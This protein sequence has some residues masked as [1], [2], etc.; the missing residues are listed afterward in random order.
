[1]HFHLQFIVW[2]RF[3]KVKQ[4]KNEKMQLTRIQHASSDWTIRCE[5]D[6]RMEQCA[7]LIVESEVAKY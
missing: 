6:L 4:L 1:M 7:T 3:A 2:L 5:Y